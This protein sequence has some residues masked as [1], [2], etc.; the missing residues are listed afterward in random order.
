[1]I[2]FIQTAIV[3]IDLS[4]NRGKALQNNQSLRGYISGNNKKV[5]VTGDSYVFGILVEQQT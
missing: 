5:D 3:Q 2:G 4:L 1:M